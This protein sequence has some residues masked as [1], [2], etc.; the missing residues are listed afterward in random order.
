MQPQP[1]VN[2]RPPSQRQSLGQSN[3]AF[4]RKNAIIPVATTAQVA[5][6]RHKTS[7]PVNSQIA[8]RQA[9][10]ATKMQTVVVQNAT[11][12]TANGFRYPRFLFRC[13][14][15]VKICSNSCALVCETTWARLPDQHEPAQAASRL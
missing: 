10:T 5:T 9:T 6:V 15:S 12:L 2:A 14:A 3:K 8:S 11:R 4:A 7:V 13:S 1:I